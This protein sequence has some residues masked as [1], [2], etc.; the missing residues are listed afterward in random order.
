MLGIVVVAKIISILFY[1]LGILAS[2]RSS[3]LDLMEAET[4]KVNVKQTQSCDTVTS[5]VSNEE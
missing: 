1:G 2:T 3:V 5:G 4:A